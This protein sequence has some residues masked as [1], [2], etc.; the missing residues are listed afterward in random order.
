MEVLVDPDAG[1]A[2]EQLA[3]AD[4]GLGAGQRGSRAETMPPS[5]FAKA[6]AVAGPEGESR[7]PPLAA[8]YITH[9]AP[10]V[11]DIREFFASF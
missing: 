9:P 3:Q 6:G 11:G 2:V 7:P 8:S 10:V 1:R 4:P 5:G